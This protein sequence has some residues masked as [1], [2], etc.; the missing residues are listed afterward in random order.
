MLACTGRPWIIFISLN[1]NVVLSMGEY[2]F[3]E[4]VIQYLMLLVKII[5][6]KINIPKI[7]V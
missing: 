3:I 6:K 2:L 5:F 4:N 1:S 7:L